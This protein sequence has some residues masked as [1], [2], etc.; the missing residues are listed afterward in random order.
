MGIFS[1]WRLIENY[2]TALEACGIDPKSLPAEMCGRI[3]SYTSQHYDQS[4]FNKQ[5]RPLSFEIE[6]SAT[7]VALCVLGPAKFPRYNNKYGISMQHTVTVAAAACR[8]GG[9]GA[10]LDT[11]II[12]TVGKAGYLSQD[13]AELYAFM[14]LPTFVSIPQSD[15]L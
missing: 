8:V 1:S 15:C 12:Q 5:E 11:R 7:L 10:T 13:F 9:S 3:C 6:R 2:R 14:L 4:K